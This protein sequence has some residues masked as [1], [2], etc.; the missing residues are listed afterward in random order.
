MMMADTGSY[1]S[2]G[3]SSGQLTFRNPMGNPPSEP[4]DTEE[5][6]SCESEVDFS[7][8]GS[9]LL[10]GAALPTSPAERQEYIDGKEIRA[11]YV[12][13]IEV[14]HPRGMPMMIT[15]I[16]RVRAQHKLG[17]EKKP[18][19]RFVIS[20]TGLRVY[21]EKTQLLRDT[22][23]LESIS[24]IATL[25]SN[26][27]VFA[28]ITTAATGRRHTHTCHVFKTNKKTLKI[29]DTIGKCFTLQAEIVREAG[30][31]SVGSRRSS[32]ASRSS[33]RQ[34]G[35][36]RGRDGG[37]ASP[38]GAPDGSPVP[39][40]PTPPSRPPS[41]NGGPRAS[42]YMDVSPEPARPSQSNAA[43]AHKSSSLGQRG[44][45][46]GPSFK[47]VMQALQS[48]IKFGLGD[49]VP[50]GARNHLLGLL[51]QLG[52]LHGVCEAEKAKLSTKKSKLQADVV[53]L[54]QKLARSIG[55]AELM[56]DRLDQERRISRRLSAASAAEA[57]ALNPTPRGF[58]LSTA[59]VLRDGSGE[60]STAAS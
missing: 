48:Q 27:K 16:S 58:P 30:Q 35:A 51:A 24:F 15:A 19:M 14:P 33:R 23:P 59:V 46:G 56:S 9:A 41:T 37:W 57:P 17:K 21:D 49:T 11:K 36:P 12:G 42:G 39:R 60:T 50:A 7:M 54:K 10:G 8:M 4:A 55:V 22:H 29:K 53:D 38:E 13:A 6:Q 40:G 25:P 2:L 18:K 52:V 26:K 43:V 32:R 31:F 45:S 1:D 20:T 34:S 47:E 5:T 3:G 28:F 44:T